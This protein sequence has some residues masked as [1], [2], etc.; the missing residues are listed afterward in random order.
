MG[1]ETLA[2]YDVDA[3]ANFCNTRNPD[4]EGGACKFFNIWTAVVNGTVGQTTCA[5]VRINLPAN[6][7]LYLCK[8]MLKQTFSISLRP[9]LAQQPISGHPQRPLRNHVVLR[10][11]PSCPTVVSRSSL[12][13][14]EDR[15]VPPTGTQRGL[16]SKHPHQRIPPVRF[17]AITGHTLARYSRPSDFSTRRIRASGPRQTLLTLCQDRVTSSHIS[18]A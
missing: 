9:I 2:T 1:S 4:S 3:C 6:S 11:F 17:C 15:S 12:H 5:M 16:W 18:I 10:V 13:A 8:R 7:S 14:R